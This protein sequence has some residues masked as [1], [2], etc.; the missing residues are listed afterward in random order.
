MIMSN[1]NTK[2][3]EKEALE[4]QDEQL[5]FIYLGDKKINKT[6]PHCGCTSYKWDNN[7]LKVSV[8]TDLVSYVL[9]K[10]VYKNK[11][12]YNKSTSV[13]VYYDDG[14]TDNLKID[15]TVKEIPNR[16]ETT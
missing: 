2:K 12:T 6:L 1:W 8:R 13:D 15:L 7:T 10:E 14:S 9:P 3:I 11:K 16:N 4:G 5:E